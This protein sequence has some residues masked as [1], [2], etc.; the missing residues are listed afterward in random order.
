[1]RDYPSWCQECLHFIEDK[2]RKGVTAF[3]RKEPCILYR[4]F[5]ENRKKLV[6]SLWPPRWADFARDQKT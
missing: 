5:G 4:P 1:M 3:H 2:C 6:G